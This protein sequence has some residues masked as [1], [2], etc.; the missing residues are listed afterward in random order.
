M[1]EPVEV[2]A[3]AALALCTGTVDTLNGRV[4]YSK[5]LLDELGRTAQPLDSNS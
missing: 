4:A 1:A 5:V 3:E 2:I